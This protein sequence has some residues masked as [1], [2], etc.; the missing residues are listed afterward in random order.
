MLPVHTPTRP[1]RE[2]GDGATTVALLTLYSG[3]VRDRIMGWRTTAT[4]LG[5]LIR[6]LFGGALGRGHSITTGSL[7]AAGVAAL[8]LA[9]LLATSIPDPGQRARG[10][11]TAPEPAPAR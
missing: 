6:P 5:G 11:S 8:V 2:G 3:S 1:A 7:I 10:E 9:V 4:T